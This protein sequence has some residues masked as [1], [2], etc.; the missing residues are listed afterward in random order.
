MGL[1]E[2]IMALELTLRVKLE[3]LSTKTFQKNRYEA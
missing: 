3:F 2:F 1:N